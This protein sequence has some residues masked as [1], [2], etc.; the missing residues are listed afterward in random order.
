MSTEASAKRALMKALKATMPDAV[1]WRVEDKF[2]GGRPDILVIWCGKVAAIEVKME[3]P[4]RRAQRTEL[5]ALTLRKLEAAGARAW[6]LV[7]WW[8]GKAI[9]ERPDTQVL[10][11]FEGRGIHAQVA[12]FVADSLETK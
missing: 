2:A 12:R 1:C 7:Y 4:G 11:V 9:L 10:A 5:Q 8:D 6:W 3:R